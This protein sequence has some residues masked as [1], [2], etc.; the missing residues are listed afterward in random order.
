MWDDPNSIG[1]LRFNN[2]GG[3][4]N[5]GSSTLLMDLG[6]SS[7]TFYSRNNGA[8]VNFG[9]LEGGPNTIIKQ[10]TSSSG[11]NTYFIGGLNLNT[12]F[13]G[14]IVDGGSGSGAYLSLVKVGTGT[15]TLQGNVITNVTLN[16]AD[17]LIPPTSLQPI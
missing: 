15:L 13:Q 9:A 14:Q 16:S 10:G 7:V 2:G 1:N 12:T 3:N 5:T 6:D 17:L 8:S 11:T 4:N